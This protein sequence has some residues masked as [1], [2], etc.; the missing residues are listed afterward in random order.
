[1]PR[2]SIR[3]PLMTHAL[4]LALSISLSVVGFSAWAIY[5]ATHRAYYRAT[6]HQIINWSKANL[7]TPKKDEVYIEQISS[8]VTGQFSLEQAR[9]IALYPQRYPSTISIPANI[10][11]SE[12]YIIAT[13][14]KT[15]PS[16]IAWVEISRIIF[17]VVF[18]SFVS[19]ALITYVV[20]RQL[21]P[22]LN[23]LSKLAAQPTHPSIEDSDTPQEIFDIATRFR[24]TT[25]LLQLARENAERQH[26]QLAQMQSK[27]VRATKLAST[28]RLAAGLAHE[29]GNPLAAVKGYLSLLLEESQS[30][31]QNDVIKRSLIQLHRM[32]TTLQKLLTYARS[33]S[34]TQV[35]QEVFDLTPVVYEAIQL[36]QAHHCLKKVTIIDNIQRHIAVSGHPVQLSQVIVNLLL[37]SGQATQTLINPTISLSAHPSTDRLQIHITD[38]GPGVPLEHQESIFDPFFTTKDVGE[39][40][41]LGLAVSRSM[42]ES[43]GGQLELLTPTHSAVGATFVLTIDLYSRSKVIP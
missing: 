15:I 20:Y 3:Q 24:H 19:A 8:R 33:S 39:G 22:S 38:N 28:G 1:M 40:A 10:N 32:H 12:G 34:E 16:S 14:P 30:E 37:N 2:T 17:F 27:L 4:A 11:Q 7:T 5:K 31:L 9:Q 43:M 26:H 18:F 13:L 25:R 41:G 23:A 6:R 21:I 36:A 35:R 29:I 42:M